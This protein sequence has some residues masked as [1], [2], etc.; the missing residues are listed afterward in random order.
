LLSLWT[1]REPLRA[2]VS[3]S[4]GK[5]SAF[6]L[7]RAKMG[8]LKISHL[9]NML[10]E[11]GRLSRSHGLPGDILKVQAQGLG[12]SLI[13]SP[14][15]WGDYEE[16]FKKR[17]LELKREGVEVGVFG[18]IDL[19]EHR[20]WV[21]RVCRDVGVKPVLP[22]WKNDRE[23]LLKDFV[24]A[25]FRAILVSVRTD[26]LTGEWLGREID[27]EF[28]EE[29]KS[30]DSIDLCGEK[31]EY[32]TLVFDGPIFEKEVR[33]SAGKKIFQDNHGFLEIKVV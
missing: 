32:H 24:Q 10:S 26:L 16:R 33:F 8:G 2:F 4:G 19:E 28:I 12:I 6:S 14:T 3:W 21:E 22:L 5:E 23:K 11:N 30:L 18:D 29:M 27:G 25:G 20:N 13:Q 15:S 1:D 7:Y 31:G 17:V 9:L